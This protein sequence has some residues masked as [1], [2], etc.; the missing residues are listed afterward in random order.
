MSDN[1]IQHPRTKI[2]DDNDLHVAGLLHDDPEAG[3][4]P[5]DPEPT[6]ESDAARWYD[7][8]EAY[9]DND[10]GR[11]RRLIDLAAGSIR[12]C[13]TWDAWMIYEDGRWGRNTSGA[14]GRYAHQVGADL[15]AESRHLESKYAETATKLYKQANTCGNKAKIQNMIGV[16]QDIEGVSVQPD[17]F[18][19]N[20]WLLGIENGVVDLRSGTWRRAVRGDMI[21]HRAG[22]KWE[23]GATCPTWDR[24]LM[25]IMCED[26]ELVSYLQRAVGYSLTG[27][28]QEQCL[29]FLYGA[30]SNGKST[31]LTTIQALMGSYARQSSKDLLLERRHDPHPVEFADLQGRRMVVCGEI[32]ERCRLAEDKVK[33]LTG[34]DRI[35]A[36]WMR[37]NPFEFDPTHTIW[38]PG[39]HKPTIKGMD[40]GIWRRI[41]LVP[42]LASFKDEQKDE[43]LPARLREELP[44]ILLWAVRGC[45]AWQREGLGQPEAVKQATGSYRQEMDQYREFFEDECVLGPGREVMSGHLYERFRSWAE[46]AGFKKI[47]NRPAWSAELR[48]RG[49]HPRNSGGRRWVGL[50]LRA[51]PQPDE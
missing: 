24:F 22:V 30:G 31:F 27:S 16:A 14:L 46:S 23:Q 18:D 51:P 47:P 19:A 50:D 8:R 28:I 3:T 1:V 21:T 49:F 26:A 48:R 7:R 25:E 45:M 39:N 20:P 41:R 15:L 10:L 9:T 11:A 33:T 34:G 6:W 32:K 35:N 13:F 38:Q 2:P 37:E 42:F 5:V 17:E 12:Y 44:G 43:S 40:D 29:F 4:A 36:R